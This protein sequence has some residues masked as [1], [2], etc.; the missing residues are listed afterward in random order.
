MNKPDIKIFYKVFIDYII[1]RL[2]SNSIIEIAEDSDKYNRY[3]FKI[4]PNVI[5]TWTN[6]NKFW[7]FKLFF[8]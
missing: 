3:V 8:R 5:I 4:Y 2:K 7:M 6:T 1:N